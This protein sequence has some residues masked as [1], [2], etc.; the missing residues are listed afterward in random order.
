MWRMEVYE[1]I[2]RQNSRFRASLG[3]MRPV[4]EKRGKG[5][6][7]RGGEVPSLGNLSNVYKLYILCAPLF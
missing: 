6:E 4:S 3:Y 5:E 1:V 2:L 7:G